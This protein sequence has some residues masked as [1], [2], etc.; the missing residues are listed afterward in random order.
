MKIKL[1]RV[2]KYGD[3][4][5]VMNLCSDSFYDQAYNNEASIADLA[6]KFCNYGIFSIAKE[7][8]GNIL[9]FIA[10]YANDSKNKQ[11]F[12]S[13][14]IVNSSFQNSGVGSLLLHDCIIKCKKAGMI[15]LKLEVNKSNKKAI[16][17][18]KKRGFVQCDESANSIFMMIDL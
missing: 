15:S 11:G 7:Q 9:G 1:S 6:N 3:I 2:I 12:I 14:I 17:F 8:N 13:M 16:S 4:V 5:D 18:Y 10:Y